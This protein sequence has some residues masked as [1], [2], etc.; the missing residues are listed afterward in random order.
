MTVAELLRAAVTGSVLLLVFALGLRATAEEATFLLRRPAKLAR[1]ILVMY[2][3]VPGAAV[4]L[5]WLFEF[6]R[7]V[8]VALVATAISPVPPM[9]PGRQ[10]RMGGRAGYV[11]GLLVAMAMC[12]IVTLPVSIEVI[13]RVVGRPLQIDV[14][15]VARL[16]GVTVLAPIVLG[17]LVRRFAPA[18]AG[19][20]GVPASRLGMLLLMIGLA[21][22]LVSSAPAMWQLL[23]NGTL[24][25]VALVVAVA[26]AAGHFLGGAD[27]GE[28]TAL[29]VAAAMRHPGVALAIARMNAPDDGLVPAAV[30][31]FVFQAAIVTSLYGVVASRI[32]RREA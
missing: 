23:G 32:R 4:L 30:L 3:I 8:E 1:A 26:V 27:P 25:A 24:L 21:P 31:V 2:V 20:L 9:L 19:R 5:A 28:R 17:I 11:Y 15:E 13:E 16:V 29:V 14:L 7:P 12:A 10:I 18:L 6:R 22:L